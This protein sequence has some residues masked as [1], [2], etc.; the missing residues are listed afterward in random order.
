MKKDCILDFCEGWKDYDTGFDPSLPSWSSRFRDAG[1][2]Q[3][4]LKHF[5]LWNETHKWCRENFGERHYAWAGNT[6]WFENEKDAVL[7][8]LKWS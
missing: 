3:A 4:E 7:F 5:H 8:I 1:Y 2:Y 6:F